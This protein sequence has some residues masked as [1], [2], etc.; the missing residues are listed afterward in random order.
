[1]Q[2]DLPAALT[3]YQASFAISERL[4]KSDPENVGWQRDLSESYNKVGDLF[5]KQGKIEEAL[6]NYH[7]G[8]AVVE[9]LVAI[10]PTNMQ[11]QADIVEFNYDLAIHGDDS[12][13]RFAFVVENLKKLQAEHAL[14][15]EQ[16][17]WLTEAETA[18]S[19]L[20]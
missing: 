16:Q 7:A 1:V 12:A 4:A 9:R 3:S 19:K 2:A 14:N 15:Q 18:I 20:N 10:D 8:L 6:K 13:R 11:R 17:R 5:V